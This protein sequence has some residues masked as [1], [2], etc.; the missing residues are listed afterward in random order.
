MAAASAVIRLETR[1]SRAARSRDSPIEKK[2]K[3]A[4]VLPA[5]RLKISEALEGGVVDA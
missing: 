3:R 4:S 2:D 5:P 1:V